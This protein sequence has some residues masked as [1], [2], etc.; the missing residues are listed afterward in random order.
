MFGLGVIYKARCQLLCVLAAP[1]V[2]IYLLRGFMALE[3]SLHSW[4][5]THGARMVDF[6]G[7]DMPV[8]YTTI[9]DEHVSVRND[10]GIF[11]I[12]HMGRLRIHGPDSTNFLQLT[13]SN[14]SANLRA[15][16]VRYNLVCNEKGNILDDILVYQHADDFILVVNA[17][18]RLKIVSWLE[19]NI[20]SLNVKI[21]DQTLSTSMIAVQGPKSINLAKQLI[22]N[23]ISK[24]GYYFSFD[25]KTMDIPSLVS[26]TG[27]TGEDGFELI[28]P[29]TEASA[30]FTALIHQGAAPMPWR[31]MNHDAGGFIKNQN[32]VIKISNIQIDRIGT[33]GV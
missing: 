8:Q 16:Q 14:N 7:W 20:K 10:S 18:N 33:E 28:V 6:G 17:S 32:L 25:S 29:A 30:L 24:L 23:D 11:D 19:S 13:C 26:R 4:H 27:Y 21:E 5:S 2:F 31:R 1:F 3:T 12:G 9:V 22:S 15:G